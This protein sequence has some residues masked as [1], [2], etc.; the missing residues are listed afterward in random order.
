M[1]G[2]IKSKIPSFINSLNK[3]AKLDLKIS[4]IIII[5]SILLSYWNSLMFYIGIFAII[6]GI[7]PALFALTVVNIYKKWFEK[8]IN[9]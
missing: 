3:L 4:A 2:R 9:K 8:K 7:I 1:N 6:W 5:I